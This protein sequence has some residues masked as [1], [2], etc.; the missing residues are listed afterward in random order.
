MAERDTVRT[1]KCPRDLRLLINLRHSIS[2]GGNPGQIGRLLA[3]NRL[4]PQRAL[5]LGPKIPSS[6]LRCAVAWTEV[7]CGQNIA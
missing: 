7:W 3:H 2:R 4:R 6:V 5:D 1:T